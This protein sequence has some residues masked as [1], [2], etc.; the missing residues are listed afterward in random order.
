MKNVIKFSEYGKIIDKNRLEAILV[1]NGFNH[2]KGSYMT[3]TKKINDKT[4]SVDLRNEYID[5]Y[6]AGKKIERIEYQSKPYDFWKQL[7]FLNFI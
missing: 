4:Y 3:F 5:F 1:A 2:K 6:V 7:E